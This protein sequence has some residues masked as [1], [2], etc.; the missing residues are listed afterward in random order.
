MRDKGGRYVFPDQSCHQRSV[1][2]GRYRSL[3]AFIRG[4]IGFELPAGLSEDEKQVPTETFFAGAIAVFRQD[5]EGTA[6]SY[7]GRD[8]LEACGRSLSG[9]GCQR[10][11][12]LVGRWRR[13]R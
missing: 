8:E 6:I 4:R 3:I 9:A 13:R 10:A 1:V 11:E 2:A 5:T 12:K 7:I